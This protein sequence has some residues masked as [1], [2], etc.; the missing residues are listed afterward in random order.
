MAIS[1]NMMVLMLQ[2][3]SKGRLC[4]ASKFKPEIPWDLWC[5][6]LNTNASATCHLPR[7]LHW[8]TIFFGCCQQNKSP[9]WILLC[10][11]QASDFMTTSC[12][13]P[14][15]QHNVKY[16]KILRCTSVFVLFIYFFIVSN[17]T[18]PPKNSDIIH[19]A[20]AIDLNGKRLVSLH[21]SLFL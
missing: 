8:V 18:I 2:H 21:S 5:T 13:A 14:L 3:T 17:P 15:K 12:R 16:K 1:I 10:L 7:P 6:F 20:W 4:K 11:L 19:M 9:F